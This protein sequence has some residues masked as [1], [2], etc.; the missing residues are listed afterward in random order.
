MRKSTLTVIKTIGLQFSMKALTVREVSRNNP[1]IILKFLRTAV[2]PFNQRVT[3]R[4]MDLNIISIMYYI[5][6]F[7]SALMSKPFNVR[8]ELV[9]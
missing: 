6:F 7:S 1:G 4:V 9:H 5:N 3:I 8:L 2:T